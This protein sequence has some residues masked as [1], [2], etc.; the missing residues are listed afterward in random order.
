[1][2]YK[3]ILDIDKRLFKER[4]EGFKR[5]VYEL[6]NKFQHDI[7]N[8]KMSLDIDELDGEDFITYIESHVDE[9]IMLEDVFIN[10]FRSSTIISVYTLIE[11]RMNSLAELIGKLLK[12]KLIV[13][14]LSGNGISRGKN[15]LEKVCEISFSDLNGY[16]SPIQD[17]NKVRN[18]IVHCE[19]N[20]LE[21]KNSSK[22]MNIIKST[23]GLE[24]KQEKYIVVKAQYLETIIDLSESFF[25][26]LVKLS[27][28]RLKD[29]KEIKEPQAAP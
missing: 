27:L 12:T 3:I 29:V 6:E 15:Y 11:F 28:L 24:L 26:E 1:M 23:N 14:D 17:L 10:Q 20:I 22:L 25:D 16:W 5:Y 4:I 13:S 18:C 19:S 21:S 9:R 8:L 7:K 2:S